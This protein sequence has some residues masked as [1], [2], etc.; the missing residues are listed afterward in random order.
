MLKE[1]YEYREEI[2]SYIILEM[3]LKT[4]ERDRFIQTC[5]KEAIDVGLIKTDFTRKVMMKMG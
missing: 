2:H 4:L 5:V 3:F 1:L